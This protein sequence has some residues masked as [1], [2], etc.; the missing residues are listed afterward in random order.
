MPEILLFSLEEGFIRIRILVDYG[1]VRK[2]KLFAKSAY[3]WNEGSRK[4][5]IKVCQRHLMK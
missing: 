3:E 4:K 1:K 5:R 2:L